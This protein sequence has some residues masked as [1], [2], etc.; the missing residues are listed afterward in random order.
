MAASS[1]LVTFVR[2]QLQSLGDDLRRHPRRP[3]RPATLGIRHLPEDIGQL[4]IGSPA[5]LLAQDEASARQWAPMIIMELLACGPVL[6][7]AARAQ[8]V[9]ALWEHIPLRQAYDAGRLRVALF[10]PPAQAR[11]RRDG[12]MHW[13][14][15]LR[16][17]GLTAGAA[18]ACWTHARCC[19]GLP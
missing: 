3:A 5:L 14:E 2:S 17:S 8:D 13:T 4:P 15:E 9:D 12:L 6:L 7:L 1:S 18:C 11:L 19:P 10:P 16:R